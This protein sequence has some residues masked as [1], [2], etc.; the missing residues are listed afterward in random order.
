MPIRLTNF[1]FFSRVEPPTPP[2]EAREI[3]FVRRRST[4]PTILCLQDLAEQ[5]KQ[6]YASRN[7]SLKGP[8]PGMLVI[9]MRSK[10]QTIVVF[11]SG[12]LRIMGARIKTVKRA[13]R[14]FRKLMRR[15]FPPNLHLANVHV[16]TIT[17]THDVGREINLYKLHTAINERYNNGKAYGNPGYMNLYEP[18][19]FPALQL[20]IWEWRGTSTYS[21]R[22]NVY[23][24]DLNIITRRALLQVTL[25]TLW[26][27]VHKYTYV[28]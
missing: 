6:F 19:L 23:L 1:V 11:A 25:T 8:C 12:K 26:T 24:P 10:G 7:I 3:K 14:A 17:A 15:I 13:K 5:A 21:L 2:Q 16:Q 27:D 20:R 28:C 9:K 18:E 22:A 4:L